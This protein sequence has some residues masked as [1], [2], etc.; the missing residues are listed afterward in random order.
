MY[1][2]IRRKRQK[3]MVC[4]VHWADQR[5]HKFPQKKYHRE[6]YGKLIDH[7]CNLM[8]VCGNCHASHAK[9]DGYIWGEFEFRQ[10]LKKYVKDIPE[11]T[12][13]FSEELD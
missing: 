13:T 9:M 10:A 7:P 12:K 11:G 5:H 4:G 6:V 1:D 3:C 8:L 2:N